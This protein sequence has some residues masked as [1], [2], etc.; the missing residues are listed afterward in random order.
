MD[1]R[2]IRTRLVEAA[3]RMPQSHS[4]GYAAGV[5]AAARTWEEYVL[6]KNSGPNGPS[7]GTLSLPKKRV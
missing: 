6:S 3:A 1:E 5:L 7:Q 4:E 2:E